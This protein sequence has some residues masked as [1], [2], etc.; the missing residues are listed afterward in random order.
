MSAHMKCYTIYDHP[1]DFPDHFVV[2]A[3]LIVSGMLEPQATDEHYLCDTLDK[4]RE[5]IPEGFVRIQRDFGD[6]PKIV[7]TWV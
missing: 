7:E 1:L 6:D 5:A 3:W 2:R 4:A